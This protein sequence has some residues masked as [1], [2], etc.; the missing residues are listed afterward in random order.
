MNYCILCS[1]PCH[2]RLWERRAY[3]QAHPF[4]AQKHNRPALA[5]LACLM[6]SLGDYS[7]GIRGLVAHLVAVDLPAAALVPAPEEG[8][9][10]HDR[11]LFP[12]RPVQ[13]PSSCACRREVSLV[14]RA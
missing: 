10:D 1:S 6:F 11:V 5:A 9:P 14:V 7:F 12:G 3:C 13:D 2:R 4:R 8:Y